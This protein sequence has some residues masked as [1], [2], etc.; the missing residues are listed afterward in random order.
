[1]NGHYRAGIT[2]NVLFEEA[3]KHYK[4]KDILKSVEMHK[5]LF[6]ENLKVD[7]NTQRSQMAIKLYFRLESLI[8]HDAYIKLRDRFVFRD[9][10]ESL[11]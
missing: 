11:Y 5:E 4:L 6:H 9:N 1:M 2:Q 7:L 3:K 10:E 8:P